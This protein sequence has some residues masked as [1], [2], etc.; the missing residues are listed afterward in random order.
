[1]TD[2]KN[3]RLPH[4]LQLLADAAGVDVALK[5]ALERGGSRLRIPQKAAGSILEDLVGIDA[6]QAIVNDLADER[7]DIPLA[8]SILSDW[9]R[10][11][12]WSQ[13]KRA[14]AL[15]MSRRTIQYKDADN[16]P[17]RQTSLFDTTD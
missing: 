5:I 9:L 11:L 3:T 6:A 4:G 2:R 16:T 1:M 10:A 7:I 8:K 13:E 12:G 15:K 14:M 17:T